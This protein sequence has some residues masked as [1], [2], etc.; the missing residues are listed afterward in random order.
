MNTRDAE[1][2]VLGAGGHIGSSVLK[3]LGRDGK[4]LA[5]VHR[6]EKARSLKTDTVEPVIVDVSDTDALRT[7][8]QRARRA[9]LLNPPANPASDTNKVELETARSIASA[10]KGSGLE[11]IVVASTYGAQE[12]D[13][14]GDLSVL[15]E[16]EKR[17]E[18][19]GIPAAINRGAYY[20]TNF[21]MLLPATKQ[22]HLATPFPP[23]MEIPMVS[24]DD[25]GR[26]AAER[27]KSPSS[28][29]GI[30][31]VEGPQ[32]YTF[33]QV[34]SVFSDVLGN[35]VAVERIPRDRIEDSFRSNGFSEQAARAYARMMEVSIDGGFELPG[36]PWKGSIS[37]RDYVELLVRR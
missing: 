21:D 31:Y 29:I 30:R 3:H 32:R 28:D 14:I 5:I 35:P 13:G 11:K 36:N 17:V 37:L 6:A 24:P 4:I 22:G 7:V 20:F 23:D 16:F 25:L 26:A 2:V 1:Y 27:L 8:L 10:L 15:Y 9:F 12:G 34:A 19:T 18:A 33:S